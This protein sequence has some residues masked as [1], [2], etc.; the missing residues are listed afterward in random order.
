MAEGAEATMPSRFVR[1]RGALSMRY[2]RQFAAIPSRLANLR[3]SEA[4]MKRVSEFLIGTFVTEGVT[5]GRDFITLQT[6]H[7]MKP[8]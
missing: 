4:L 5:A 3:E 8:K 7:G 1:S 6:K 2:L